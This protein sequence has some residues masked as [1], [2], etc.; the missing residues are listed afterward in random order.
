MTIDAHKLRSMIY[1]AILVIF[2][3]GALG[4]TVASG[5]FIGREINAAMSAAQAPAPSADLTLDIQAVRLIAS[6]LQILPSASQPPSAPPAPTPQPPIEPLPITETSS[7]TNAPPVPIV[8]P[9]S[10]IPTPSATS[11]TSTN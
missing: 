6:H 11:T 9:T 2:L 7:T 4:A 1:P 3:L 5:L 8:E 10:T